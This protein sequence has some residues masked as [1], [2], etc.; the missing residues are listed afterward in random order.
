MMISISELLEFRNNLAK[1]KSFADII[2]IGV[3]STRRY[4]AA[5]S[6]SIY[7]LNKFGK[8]TRVFIDGVDIN[9]KDISSDW[10][11]E[12]TLIPGESFTGKAV[13]PKTEFGFGNPH[14]SNDLD[15]LTL[16]P[17]S[18]QKYTEM[19]GRLFCGMAM[20]LNGQNR[21][22]G[23]LEIIN[24]LDT[25]SGI[26]V[27]KFSREDH[28]IAATL[29]ISIANAL[30]FLRRRDEF[31]NLAAISDTLIGLSSEEIRESDDIYQLVAKD[32]VRDTSPH[33]VCIIRTATPDNCLEIVALEVGENVKLEYR[34][35]ETIKP[36]EHRIV[37]DVFKSGKAVIIHDISKEIEYFTSAEWI[38][39]NGFVSF[40]SF[41]LKTDKRI[42]GT[43][44]LYT[45]YKHEFSDLDQEYLKTILDSLSI[46]VESARIYDELRSLQSLRVQHAISIAREAGYLSHSTEHTMKD[47]LDGIY[48]QLKP[49]LNASRDKQD[50]IVLETLSKIEDD[51]KKIRSR[52][53]NIKFTQVDINYVIQEIIQNFKGE[54]DIFIDVQFDNQIP[55]IE[56][57]FSEIYDIL[58]NLVSNAVRAIHMQEDPAGVVSVSTALVTRKGKN[59]ILI[60][61]ID[62]GVGIPNELGEKIYEPKFST[63]QELGGTGMGLFTVK[64]L[65][66]NY[67]G[68]IKYQSTVGLGTTFEVLIPLEII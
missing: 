61:V 50:K 60:S 25:E 7:L 11:L 4:L 31:V 26:F 13:V 37:N 43:L 27:A 55:L 36:G 59:F 28:L 67:R 53:D 62:T 21:T 54:R 16:N 49:Y 23:V 32:L 44:S 66:D 22:F 17:N 42:L 63:T 19:L 18:R 35:L 38:R 52:L 6:V 3:V 9:G 47:M 10:F 56:A 14:I 68:E 30:S 12:D 57:V 64:K 2:E 1:Q 20:P 40:A 65:L 58:H 46:F 5:Q 39:I 51:F 41:P 8:L 33:N 48:R 34:S 24:K 29:S 15:S 45:N